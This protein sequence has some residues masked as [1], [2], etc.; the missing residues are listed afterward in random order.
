MSS[1]KEEDHT[2]DSLGNTIIKPSHKPNNQVPKHPKLTIN[3]LPPEILIQIFTN[4]DPIYLNTLRLVCKNWNYIINDKELWMK[5][6]QL[7]FNIPI[8]SS[9]FPSLSQSLN[10]M[11]EYFTRL[12]VNKNWKR[13]ISVHKTY[14]IINNEHRFN[15]ITMVD[16]GMNKILTYDKRYNNISI[17][18]L[19][20]GK[21]QGFIPGSISGF[22]T[23]VLCFD[24]NWNYLVTGMKN[25]EVILKNLYTSTSASQRSSVT[26]FD[27][28][29]DS[30]IMDI[31]MNKDL[32]IS[33]SYNGNLRCWNLQ[34]KV[35]KEFRL[36]E[37][38]Y[39]I[40]SDF[41]KHIIVN[42][43]R[44]I[45]V[46]DYQAEEII[47]KIDLGFII[48]EN[49]PLEYDLLIRLKNKLDVDYGTKKV[50]ICYKSHIQVFYFDN[51][52]HREMKLDQNVEVID[53]RFQ[54]ATSNKFFNRNTYVVGQD[55][56]LYGN[57]LSDGSV[58]IWNVREDSVLITPITQIYPELDHK[59]Y[60]HGL[61]H[62]IAR[63]N[64]LEI[65]SFAMNGT[66]LAIGGYNG[67]TNV[68]D[69]FTGKFIREISIKYPARFQHM[70]NS[71]V[72]ISSIQLNPS[73]TDNNGII[74]CGDA[75]QYFE[76][77]EIKQPPGKQPQRRQMQKSL[78]NRGKNESVKKIRD[79]LE[80]YDEEKHRQSHADRLLDKY[81][82]NKYED[83]DE[84]LMMALALSESMNNSRDAS[85]ISVNESLLTPEELVGEG[86]QDEEEMDEELRR[87][88]ELSLIEH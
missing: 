54:I 2:Q 50:I 74:I 60:S 69:V 35:V 31:I 56:L 70:H 42:T 8:T 71:L 27:T 13:G 30:P 78:N 47:S 26:K 83:E 24:I 18:K 33:G 62:A 29:E 53:S 17:G 76:F 3:D 67:L 25:G 84:E 85:Q 68:Y 6:F 21:N 22:L 37:V 65:T 23:D 16:F 57:L 40:S 81:N 59:K 19:S 32:I 55:G 11:N 88:L 7:R 45:F 61:N 43:D 41:K 48:N 39:N 44:H 75:V 51:H 72:P 66:M 73:Q 46:I 5:S 52:S 38:I 20:D 34:G 80:D 10:W 14:Q 15:D 12:Q 64:L 63:H 79:G 86:Q 28:M 1:L 58:I 4:L 49:E 9:S 36:E 87:A 82:G 77:G